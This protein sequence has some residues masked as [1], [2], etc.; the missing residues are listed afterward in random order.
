MFR[1]IWLVAIAAA[2]TTDFHSDTLNNSDGSYSL[3]QLIATPEPKKPA[4]ETPFY[5]FLCVAAVGCLLLC[6]W[7]YKRKRD[8]ANKKIKDKETRRRNGFFFY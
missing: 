5:I 4:D 2:T 8:I 3:T 1:L 7:L 6:A